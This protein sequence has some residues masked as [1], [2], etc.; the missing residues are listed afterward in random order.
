MFFAPPVIA[1]TGLEKRN[2][3][4]KIEIREKKERRRREDKEKRKKESKK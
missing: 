2:E 4:K 3:K 1:V